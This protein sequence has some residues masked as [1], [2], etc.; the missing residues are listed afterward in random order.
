[1]IIKKRSSDYLAVFLFFFTNRLRKANNDYPVWQRSPVVDIAGSLSAIA[2]LFYLASKY[3]PVLLSKEYVPVSV[4]VGAILTTVFGI[5]AALSLLLQGLPLK[6]TAPVGYFAVFACAWPAVMLVT[7]FN[8][9]TNLTTITDNL[10]TVLFML[11]AALFL[12]GQAR[13]VNSI[14]RQSGRSYVIPAGLC[15]SLLG[16]VLVIPNYIVMLVQGGGMPALMLGYIESAYILLLSLYAPLF[17]GNL[18]RSIKAV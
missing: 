8:T 1:M 16:F 2:V 4:R 12:L 17:V 15:M 6:N 18:A 11:F 10:F 9:Y 3:I 7:S 14:G 5:V 13:T